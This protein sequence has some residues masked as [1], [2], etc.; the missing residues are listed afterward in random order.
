MFEAPHE[1][2]AALE[3]MLRTLPETFRYAV[4]IRN[5]EFLAAQYFELLHEHNIAHVFNSW[6]RMPVDV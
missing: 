6:T 5:P 2:L 1:F 4:E 3:P